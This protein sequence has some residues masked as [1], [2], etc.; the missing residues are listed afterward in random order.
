MEFD[1]ALIIRKEWL[2]LILS[3]VKLW[4]LRTSHTKIRGVIGLIEAGSGLIVGTTHIIDSIGP[5]STE[6]WRSNVS[7][8]KVPYR[9]CE[10]IAEKWNHAWVLENS[11]KLNRPIPYQHQQGAVIWVRLH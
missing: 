1:R 5:L 4:E 3:G 10:H 8:H 11:C 6:E 2:E 9:A 7:K